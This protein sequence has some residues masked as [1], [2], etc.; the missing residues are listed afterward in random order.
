MTGQKQHIDLFKKLLLRKALLKGQTVSN[1]YVPFIGEGDISFELYRNYRIFGADLDPARA[2]TAS[3][4]LPGNDIRT[5]DCNAFPFKDM[6]EVEFQA[7]DFD[8]YSEPYLPFRSFWES[9]PQHPKKM[10]LFFTDGHLQYIKRS[11][12]FHRPDGSSEYHLDINAR[13]KVYNFYWT[14][15]IKPWFAE[16]IKKSGYNIVKTQSYRRS[17]MFYWGAVIE[18]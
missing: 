8:S 10:V 14:K 5:A 17:D 7:A 15:Y 18:R 11:G 16:Y 9:T 13:R 1:I 3:E 6:I 2:K 4:R 12:G